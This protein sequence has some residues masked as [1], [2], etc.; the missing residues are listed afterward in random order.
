MALK[1]FTESSRFVQYRFVERQY[2]EE[3]TRSANLFMAAL[4]KMTGSLLMR[5]ELASESF[6]ASMA[7]LSRYSGR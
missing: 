3:A 4:E 6:W 7:G 2:E 5:V 1:H